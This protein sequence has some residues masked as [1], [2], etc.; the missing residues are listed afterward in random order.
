MLWYCWHRMMDNGR[1]KVRPLMQ[2]LEMVWR[3]RRR[4]RMWGVRCRR[5]VTRRRQLQDSY[6]RR[7][8]RGL[9]VESRRWVLSVTLIKMRRGAIVLHKG[10]LQFLMIDQYLLFL[11]YAI[12]SRFKAASD[13]R[14]GSYFVQR[15]PLPVPHGIFPGTISKYQLSEH[16]FAYSIKL[17]HLSIVHA[18]LK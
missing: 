9:R 2:G 5:C 16:S 13:L 10:A 18:D 1:L 6:S 14:K 7:A 4:R 3:R 8:V 15:G 11:W 12:F 17:N